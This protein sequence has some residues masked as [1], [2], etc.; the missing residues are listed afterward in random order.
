M[1][2]STIVVEAAEVD[3]CLKWLVSDRFWIAVV[4]GSQ[5][6]VARKKSRVVVVDGIY[7]QFQR[8]QMKK[9]DGDVFSG[10]SLMLS[11]F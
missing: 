6:S 7:R 1:K 2:R 5:C 8:L 10:S 9:C 4:S 11:P 3:D